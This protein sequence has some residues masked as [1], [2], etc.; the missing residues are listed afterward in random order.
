MK[1]VFVILVLGCLTLVAC[2]STSSVSGSNSNQTTP[3]NA[4]LDTGI[5]SETKENNKSTGSTVVGNP[6]GLS[7]KP[8]GGTQSTPIKKSPPGSN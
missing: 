4:T 6:N 1:K 8:I 2:K 3:S 7:T 5:K